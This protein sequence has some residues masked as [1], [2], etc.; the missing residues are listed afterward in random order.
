MPLTRIVR[1][2]L[3]VV[4]LGMAAGCGAPP[5]PSAGGGKSGKGDAPSA[6]PEKVDAF[7]TK[8]RAFAADF[9]KAVKAGKGDPAQLSAEF[10]KVYAPAELEAE[11]AQGYSDA[12]AGQ[13]LKFVATEVGDDLTVVTADGR[14]VLFVAKGKAG[15]RTL[16]RV[17][18][19][20][21]L[22]IDW[23]GVSPKNLPEMKFAKGEG[24]A[25]QFAAMAFLDAA[26]TRKFQLAEGTLSDAGRA[27]LGA[28]VIDGKYNFGAF[29]NKLEE[30][31]GG[32]TQYTVSSA[33]KDTVTAGVGGRTATLKLVPGRSAADMKVDQVEVK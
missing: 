22:K 18:D 26:L 30:L 4:A 9:L 20:G 17:A 16:V 23:L 21:G 3:L 27:K 24:D 14:F 33:T 28:S 1:P 2:G 13:Q 5:Q 29:K 7:V 15:E 8:A 12:A 32:A 10:K 11:K 25:A 6:S 19:D 31:F